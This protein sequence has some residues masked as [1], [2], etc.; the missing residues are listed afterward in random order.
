M[1]FDLEQQFEIE[2][3]RRSLWETDDI[4]ILREAAFSNYKLCLMLH[5]NYAEMVEQGLEFEAENHVE[6]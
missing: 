4:E 6:R 3:Y 5:N 2:R 1:E